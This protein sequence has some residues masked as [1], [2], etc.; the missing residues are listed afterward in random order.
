[1]LEQI[2]YKEIHL[3]DE[4]TLQWILQRTMLLINKVS[5]GKEHRVSGLSIKPVRNNDVT[6]WDDYPKIENLSKKTSSTKKKK[7]TKES[8]LKLTIEVSIMRYN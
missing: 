6:K 1:M 8:L 2:Y 4:K 5:A 7:K 3:D